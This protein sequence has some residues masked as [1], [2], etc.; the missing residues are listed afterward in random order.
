MEKKKV[1]KKK[2]S[3]SAL[4]NIIRKKLLEE[5]NLREYRGDDHSMGNDGDVYYT[6]PNGRRTYPPYDSDYSKMG[7]RALGNHY[8]RLLGKVHNVYA[9]NY[10]SH[11]KGSLCFQV[12]KFLQEKFQLDS[13]SKPNGEIEW[14]EKEL[15]LVNKIE[16]SLHDLAMLS[17]EEGNKKRGYNGPEE[18]P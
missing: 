5:L 11:G 14:T 18:E 10:L 9:P 6:R 3:E 13:E 7:K 1:L 17:K 12:M 15:E 2:I 4:T 16:S 8:N